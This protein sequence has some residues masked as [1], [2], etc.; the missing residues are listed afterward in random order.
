MDTLYGGQNLETQLADLMVGL[1]A[2]R[3]GAAPGMVRKADGTPDITNYLYQSGGL[4]GTCDADST[5]INALV[6]PVGYEAVLQWFGT[7]LINEITD[8]LVGVESTGDEMATICGDCG[9]VSFKKCAQ[10]TCLGRICQMT[11]EMVIDEIGMFAHA[12]V[13]TKALFGPLTDAAGKVYIPQGGEIKNEWTLAIAGA[14]YMLALF[15]STDVWSGNPAAN[16]AGRWYM[17]G[18]DLLIN[19]GKND[20]RSGLACGAMDSII[21]NYGNQIVGATG[22]TS[23]VD[24]L[25]SVIRSIRFRIQGM[26]L[27]PNSAVIDIVMHQTTFDCFASAYACEYGLECQSWTSADGQR[28]NNI[29]AVMTRDRANQVI[30]TQVITIDG[31]QYKIY[32]DSQMPITNTSVGN[33]PV[34][35]GEIAVITRVLPGAPKGSASPG[36]GI[37]TWGEYQ[38]FRKTAGDTIQWLKQESG[39]SHFD[40]T[41]GG[42]FIVTRNVH[43]TG[44]FDARILTKTRVRLSM[45]QLAGRITNVCCNPLGTY[46][47]VS[48]SGGAYEVDGG[49]GQSPE[50]YP[51]GPCWPT[52]VGS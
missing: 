47:D 16:T 9:T 38:D 8:T 33:V 19:T 1:L 40:V 51:Y 11:P 29:D 32:I 18:F 46:P 45:P 7:S 35:C 17:T 26:R 10:G 2:K 4:F 49:T 23:I 21:V 34:R 50:A 3:Q 12:N 20:L 28:T 31:R 48:G 30:A 37:I 5:L 44:C 15:N 25:A 6:G 39:G 36:G 27:N 42:R 24:A 43:G 41:D 52:H 14:G 22:S 13:P